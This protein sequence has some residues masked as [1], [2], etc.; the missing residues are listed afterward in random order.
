VSTILGLLVFRGLMFVIGGLQESPV[1]ITVAAFL[2]LCS[3]PVIN[4]A[5]QVLW[6]TKVPVDLQGRVLATRNLIGSAMV[7]LAFLL[8]GPLADL[9]FEPLLAPG[10]ALADSVGQV[11]G[12][13]P[14]RGVAF[15]LMV[16]GSFAILVALTASLFPA[17]R[18]VERDLPDVEFRAAS[19]ATPADPGR[20][21]GMDPA[22]LTAEAEG[23]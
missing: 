23:A 22:P 19:P 5:N 17:L 14:G 8:G 7:P 1:L 12:V 15:L 6:Q 4:T 3:N 10:G 11:I 20:E 13:G 16:L 9:V 21:E 18:N 2:F